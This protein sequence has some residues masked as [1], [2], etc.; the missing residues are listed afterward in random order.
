MIRF[1]AKPIQLALLA[2]AIALLPASSVR[3]VEATFNLESATLEDLQQAFDS[4]AISSVELVTLYLNRRNL[5]DQAGMKLNA[6]V[7][8]SPNGMAEA[9]AADVRRSR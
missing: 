8:V 3:A 7:Q 6:V 9:A 5:Y 2:T 1:T 4:G